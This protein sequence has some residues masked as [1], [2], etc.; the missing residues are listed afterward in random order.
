MGRGALQQL[1]DTAGVD[2]D[3]LQRLIN[4]GALQLGRADDQPFGLSYVRRI[5][6]FWNW[7]NAGFSPEALVEL[8]RPGEL[9][10]SWLDQAVTSR[11]RRLNGRD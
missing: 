7:V 10:A 8:V 9:S 3:F 4:V 2:L 6:L 11:A 5:E 1:A